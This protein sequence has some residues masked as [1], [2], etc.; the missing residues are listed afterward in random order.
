MGR[1]SSSTRLDRAL[2]RRERRELLVSALTELLQACSKLGAVVASAHLGGRSAVVRDP[3]GFRRGAHRH[4]QRATSDRAGVH[5]RRLPGAGA[6]AS[7]TSRWSY[8][9]P[10]TMQSSP[11][12]Q[13]VRIPKIA[14]RALAGVVLRRLPDH[15][16]RP[17]STSEDGEAS[18]LEVRRT[19]PRGREVVAGLAEARPP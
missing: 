18:A 16:R 2:Q 5:A 17:R 15:P 19:E 7:A 13:C 9:W 10:H 6:P 12:D 14:R 11:H 4:P 8:A 3:Y 1:A